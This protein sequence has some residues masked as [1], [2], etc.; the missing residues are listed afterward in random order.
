MT[1]RAWFPCLALF[2]LAPVRAAQVLDVP[3]DHATPQ[4]AIDN[5]PDGAVIRIHGG[6]W[7]SITID[8]PLTLIGPTLFQGTNNGST[9]TAPIVLAGPGSGRVVLSDISTGIE[10][11]N[12]I[13][14]D[15]LAPAIDGGGFA[16]LHVLDSEIRPPTIGFFDGGGLCAPIQGEVEGR[17]GIQTSV[18]TIVIERSQILGGSSDN[19]DD[20]SGGY[21]DGPPGILAPDSAV[22]A[23]DSLVR[24]GPSGEY[25]A[26]PTGICGS[27]CATGRGGAAVVA[28]ELH[29]ANTE[30]R[31]GRGATWY[32]RATP[33]EFY[34]LCACRGP[35]GVATITLA[36]PMVLRS[37]LSMLAPPS[38]GTALTLLHRGGTG[39]V[40]IQ[41]FDLQPPGP[42]SFARGR[43][44]LGP[45][46]TVHGP[47]GNGPVSIPVPL[48]PG[49]IGRE[50][51]FQTIEPRVGLSPPVVGVIR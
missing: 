29:Q 44:F 21:P 12:A 43:Y 30:L 26:Y 13:Y 33:E 8:R 15:S 23:L 18:P 11:V 17:P 20:G 40:L 36:G 37:T 34:E 5:A 50:V 28:A 31:G 27:F 4:E 24:G 42:S 39:A 38:I 46:A 2:T 14:L 19:D 45:A 47:I 7:S 35:D 41:S 51:A 16:E 1:I 32:G 9:W 3:G 48:L 22:I 49:L 6:T 10:C 25:Y